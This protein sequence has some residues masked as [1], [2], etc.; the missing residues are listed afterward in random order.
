MKLTVAQQQQGVEVLAA[1]VKEQRAQLQRVSAQME[2][3]KSAPTVVLG[4]P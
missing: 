4:N 3:N 1:Q 2:M